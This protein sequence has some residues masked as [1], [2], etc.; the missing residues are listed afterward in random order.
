M[1][2][3]EEK[4]TEYVKRLLV[5]RMRILNNNGFYGL[6][7][8][9]MGFGLDKNCD[10]A[11]TDGEKINFGPEFLDSLSD[12]E[13]DF[14]LMH[15]ILHV[16]LRHCSRQGDRDDYL[17]N[18]AC[19]LVVN[20]NILMSNGMDKNSITLK[21]HGES[22]HRLP[23]GEE[24]HNFTAEQV[25]DKLVAIP[26]IKRSKKIKK[27]WD[28]HSKWKQSASGKGSDKG[29]DKSS[30]IEDAL[31]ANRFKNACEATK[32]KEKNG[33]KGCG[34]LPGFAERMLDELTHPKVDWRTILNEFVQ[35]EV[36][37]YSFAPPDRRF[38]DTGFFLPDFN[39]TE[40]TV[41]DILFMIDTSG[42][43]SKREITA[44]YSEVKG[45]IDQFGGKLQGWLGFFDA[46]VVP[47]IPFVDESEMLDIK[48]TG[49]GG[50]SFDIIFNYVRKEMTDKLPASIIILTDGYAS[51]PKEEAAMDIPV[52]WVINNKSVKP[53]WGKVAVI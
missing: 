16:V 12:S 8:M 25:Y 44:A 21:E 34:D 11:Y 19:D 31:W 53:P 24:G 10:T 4:K 35:E 5:S 32:M 15:E 2:L 23:G 40:A 14:I 48:P 33:R 1:E 49:G 45:A 38:S 42:S 47:P 28:D 22:M 20:S 3:S 30:D 41:K 43:M 52:L 6:L 9:H 37:D 27:G 17:F 18:I 50:T 39:E 7:L 26:G 46:K 51:F 36:T 13:L 29:S